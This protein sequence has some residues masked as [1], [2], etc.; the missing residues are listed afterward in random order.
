MLI[1]AIRTVILYCVVLLAVRVMG[2]SEL[3]RMSPF[4]MVISFMIAEL[5]AMPIDSSTASLIDGVM[6]I[7]TL[8]FLQVFISWLSIKSEPIKN[9]FAGKPSIIVKD[10]K[11]NLKELQRQRI[12]NTDLMEQFRIAGFHSISDIHHAVLETSGQ[13]SVIAKASSRPVTCGDMKLEVKESALP[14]ILISDGTIYHENLI[15]S[16]LNEKT[17]KKKLS[18]ARIDSTDDVFLAFVDEHKKI[19]VYL[20]S[21]KSVPYAVEVVL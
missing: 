9:F 17:L 16:D 13:L 20:R 1:V 21:D 7:F 12:S 4:Q 6:A 19:H 11:L 8:M 2:K 14:M 5:A 10:G 15:T 3:S 18:S